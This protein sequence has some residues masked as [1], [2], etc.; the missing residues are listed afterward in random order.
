M[1]D[2]KLDLV[3]AGSSEF[4]VP[5]LAA[6]VRAGHRVT[7]VADRERGRIVEAPVAVHDE[8]RVAG[9]HGRQVHRPAEVARDRAGADVESKMSLEIRGR[10]AETVETRRYPVRRMVAD[11]E[12]RPRRLDVENGERRRLVRIK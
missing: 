5:T 4:A 6:L 7:A 8:A 11:Q 2:S 10:D 1:P 3:F 9:Q 12:R